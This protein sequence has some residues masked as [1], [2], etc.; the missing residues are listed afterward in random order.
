MHRLIGRLHVNLQFAG[1]RAYVDMLLVVEH[2]D[3]VP[4]WDIVL[5]P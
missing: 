3:E 2:L 1:M 4:Y 5:V